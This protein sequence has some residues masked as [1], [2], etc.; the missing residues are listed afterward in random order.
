MAQEGEEVDDK[1][2]VKDDGVGPRGVESR[3]LLKQT[4]NVVKWFSSDLGNIVGKTDAGTIDELDLVNVS[5]QC[6]L[7][8]YFVLADRY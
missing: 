4:S 2:V 1:K 7:F 6:N 8:V 3:E 5:L